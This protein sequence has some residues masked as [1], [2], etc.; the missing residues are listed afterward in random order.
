MAFDN[1][2]ELYL[3]FRNEM[4]LKNIPEHKIAKETVFK[5]VFYSM[6][7]IKLKG[8]KGA[9]DTCDICNNCDDLT[10][11]RAKKDPAHIEAIRTYKKIHLRQQHHERRVADH[12]VEESSKLGPDGQPLQYY[13]DIDG[14]TELT[15]NFPKYCEYY[16]ILIYC[17]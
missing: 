14:M 10:R 1:I 8:A 11:G 13:L 4:K 2:T 16:H 3:E 7:N 6:P 5:S 9:M 12:I 15:G 17:P